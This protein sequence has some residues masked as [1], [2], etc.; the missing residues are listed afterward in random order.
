MR[1]DAKIRIR[2][3][4]GGLLL[5][6]LVL[7]GKLYFIQ[8]V[9][10]SF[11]SEKADR[12]YVKKDGNLLDRGEIYFTSKD[13]TLVSAA[14]Q[15]NGFALAL[16]P[17]LL[18]NPSDAFQKIKTILPD[19]DEADFITKAEKKNDPY[20]EIKTHLS[21]DVGK[22]ISDLKIKG[23]I[24]EKERWRYYPGQRLAAQTLGLMAFKDDVVTGR[25]GVERYYNHVLVR[26][27]NSAY[28]NFF[29]QIFSSIK[30]AIETKSVAEEGDVVLTIEPSVQ[31]MLTE[32]LSKVKDQYRAESAAGIIMN[33][34]T[35]EI[36]AL[37]ALPDFDPNNFKEEGNVAV[38]GNPLV[39]S[40][41][42]MGSIIKPLTMAA[43]LDAGVITRDTT[44]NDKG[45]LT[46]DEKTFSNYDGKA[47]GVVPMQ[48]ILSQS[49]N[50]GVAFVVSKLGNK[51]FAD[52]MRSF[53]LGEET[54]IDLPG[55][56]AGLI[57]NLNS[58]RD[59]EYA[60]ASFG[61]GIALTP[62]A[63]VRALSALGN[64]GV[65]V[66]PHVAREIKYKSGIT[67]KYTP[68]EEKR[69]LKKETSTEI[70]RMLVEVVDTALL[71]GKIKMEHYTVA[72]KTGTA[73]V[74]DERGGGYY[75]DR[76]LHSF[77]GYFPAYDPQFI[78][79]MYLYQPKEVQFASETL[80]MPFSNISKFL[81][82]YYE[83]SPDR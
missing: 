32:T 70:T 38:F 17:K 21:E 25:Y 35:G 10:G 59:I 78:V 20:E 12:Q 41:R 76:Y 60:T 36:L 45:S 34:K 19:L 56:V 28:S 11:F 62:I 74:A 54:G 71:K 57:D 50:T 5:V 24:V 15:K 42:E 14:T 77:F 18:E 75:K 65:L 55:E 6:A 31:R 79:F 13:G 72:A 8:I 4:G 2:V 29:L 40:V 37:S 49:L 22:A 9:H 82:N 69:V 39:E 64:G 7:L 23:V 26:N 48:Q 53:G 81:I 58:T 1:D 66:T 80:T 61:Q 27:G 43:G 51:Q 46:L 47:R 63:T 52:Y 83:V 30:G 44:Y 16:N 3:L 73:Q 68:E 33:P 67:W